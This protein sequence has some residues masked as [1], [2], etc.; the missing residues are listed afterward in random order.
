MAKGYILHF[1]LW[2]GCREAKQE[3]E[4]ST[5]TNE[6]K[7]VPNQQQKLDVMIKTNETEGV[8]N[9]QQKLDVMIRT[10]ED[11]HIKSPKDLQHLAPKEILGKTSI[12]FVGG[13]ATEGDSWEFLFMHVG[14]MMKKKGLSL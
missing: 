5:S 14:D 2:I 12:V 9:Q 8:P 4:T 10:I 13:K 6:T 7:G 11:V 3:S 1:L